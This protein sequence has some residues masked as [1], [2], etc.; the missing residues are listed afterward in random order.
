MI[1]TRLIVLNIAFALV[2]TVCVHAQSAPA[3]LPPDSYPGNQYVD[4]QGCVFT[5]A[6]IDG[7]TTWVPRVS[8]DRVQVCGQTPTFAIA[9]TETT[10]QPTA[11]VLSP[12]VVVTTTDD[13]VD[14]VATN[15][16]EP[17]PTPPPA[18]APAPRRA[19]AQ[20]VQVQTAKSPRILPAHLVDRRTALLLV[21]LPAGYEQ[22]WEDGRLNP[23]RGE[24]SLDGY[25]QSQYVMSQTVPRQ[26]VGGSGPKQVVQPQIVSDV[27]VQTSQVR[28]ERSPSGGGDR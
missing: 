8:R 2:G 23:R 6:G 1:Y 21:R 22:V 14:T 16:V 7:N 11:T 27:G 20:P 19:S 5:R 26:Y 24:Q 13:P 9:A 17:E 4:S 10:T 12:V 18:A 25:V 15:I 3:E 28:V